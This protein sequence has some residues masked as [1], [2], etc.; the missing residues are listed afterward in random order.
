MD[1]GGGLHRV[2][3]DGTLEPV[4]V[5]PVTPM[6][7][8]EVEAAA[9]TDADNPPLTP[10]AAPHLQPIPRPKTLRRALQTPPA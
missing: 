1:A 8:E 10:E 4:V 3:P 2:R 6:S 5:P 9:R 7:D